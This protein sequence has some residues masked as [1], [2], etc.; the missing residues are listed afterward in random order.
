[1]KT[2]ERK[3]ITVSLDTTAANLAVPTTVSSNSAN[4]FINF[5]PDEVVVRQVSI[6]NAIA[7]VANY[8]TLIVTSDFVDN[9]PLFTI[10]LPPDDE[11]LG[12]ALT[13]KFPIVRPMTGNFTFNYLNSAGSP[14]AIQ[15]Q[16]VMILE[17]IRY[18]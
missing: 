13:S 8:E 15:V 2:K 17:F 6:Y 4:I 11:S 16:L 5:I 9:V 10:P 14:N 1:M 12:L 18:L 3:T 7:V